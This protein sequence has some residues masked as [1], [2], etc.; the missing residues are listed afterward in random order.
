MCGSR[1]KKTNG[2]KKGNDR[3]KKLGKN[4]GKMCEEQG[5]DGEMGEKDKG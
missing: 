3:T 2:K 4:V 1:G 5:E